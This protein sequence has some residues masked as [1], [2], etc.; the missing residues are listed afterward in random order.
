MKNS[1]FCALSAPVANPETLARLFDLVSA[2]PARSAW[3]RGV[4]AYALDIL[5]SIDEYSRFEFSENGQYL[6]LTEETALN[7]AGNWFR[8]GCGGGAAALIYCDSIAKRLCNPTELKIY[9]KRGGD[10]MEWQGRALCQ[11]WQ[12]I[13]SKIVLL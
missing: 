12:L 6:P 7:G 3:G 4:R 13:S 9:Q 8:Y 11:A 10:V 1:A 5:E 2:S